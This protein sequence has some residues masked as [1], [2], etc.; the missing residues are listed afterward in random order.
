MSWLAVI[1]FRRAQRCAGWEGDAQSVV[2]AARECHRLPADWDARLGIYRDEADARRNGSLCMVPAR[3]WPAER[4]A[5][6]TPEERAARE[7]AAATARQAELERDYRLDSVVQKWIP[8]CD[9]DRID[10]LRKTSLTRPLNARDEDDLRQCMATGLL[11]HPTR[12]RLLARIHAKQADADAGAASA[13]SACRV[14]TATVRVAG[15]AGRNGT[16]R[17]DQPHGALG[18]HDTVNWHERG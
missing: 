17:A 9:A 10:G 4:E 13:Q 6:L 5:F 1:D 18:R 2:N 14:R 16:G 8:R 3:L 11:E 15:A 7:A 12:S